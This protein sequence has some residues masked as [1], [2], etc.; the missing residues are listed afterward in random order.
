[1]TIEEGE[2]KALLEENLRVSKENNQILRDMRRL[3]R[4]A[5]WAKVI[6]WTIVLVVPLLL[7]GPIMNAVDQFMTGAGG[8]SVMGFPSPE[9]I[10]EAIDLYRVE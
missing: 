7:I 10:Q 9:M 4:I 3:G 1:M 2:L 6:L 5:F 8:S